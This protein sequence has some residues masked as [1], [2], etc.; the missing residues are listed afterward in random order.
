MCVLAFVSSSPSF[1]THPVARQPFY[2]CVII[3]PEECVSVRVCV[4]ILSLC[5]CVCVCFVLHTLHLWSRCSP[6]PTGEWQRRAESLMRPPRV[7]WSSCPRSE[8]MWRRGP[9]GPELS[10]SLA[11][12]QLA[13]HSRSLTDMLLYKKREEEGERE[14]GRGLSSGAASTARTLNNN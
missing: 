12:D 10:G 6:A 9:T 3:F 13:R 14:G 4:H 8:G 5:R 7:C 1:L 11:A 2:T